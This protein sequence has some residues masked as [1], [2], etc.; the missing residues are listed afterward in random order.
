M[1]CIVLAGGLGTRLRGVIGAYPKCMAEVNHQPFLHYIF[2]YLQSQQCTRVILSLGYK[3]EVIT[4][5]V[6]TQN[7]PFE[8]DY[9]I[10]AEPLGTGGGIQ[11]AMA[12]AITENVAVLNGDTM[13]QVHLPDLFLFHQQENSDTTLALKEMLHFD[14]Y[15]VVNVDSAYRVSSFEEKKQREKGWI[16]GGIYIINKKAFLVKHLPEKFSFEKD[17]LEAYLQEKKFFGFKSNAYFIDIGIPE[18]YEQAQ[19]DFIKLFP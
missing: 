2:E 1:E 9:V 14:R 13:F 16:N 5:W 15:G 8:I 3:H 4:D 18:D 17:Y 7:K 19:Q 6:A 12:K 10:E 11:L